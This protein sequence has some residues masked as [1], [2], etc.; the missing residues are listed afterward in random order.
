[1]KLFKKSPRA[2]QLGFSLAEVSVGMGVVGIVFIT[3]YSGLSSG[4]ATV[5]MARENTR[6]TQI[7]AEKLDSIRLYSWDKITKLGYSQ[8]PF[9]T[10]FVPPGSVTNGA[11]GCT[12]SGTVTISPAPVASEYKDNMRQ[13][14]VTLS[15][16]T[17]SLK[18]HRS[19]T[20]MV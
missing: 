12:F 11:S 7:M 5:G 10:T 15:W 13:I 3:L 18:R 8:T 6:A 20:T 16:E 14:T 17:G 2:S 1:M 19:M 9:T 4:M